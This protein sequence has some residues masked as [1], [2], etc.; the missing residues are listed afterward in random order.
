[1]HGAADRSRERFGVVRRHEERGLSPHLPETRNVAEHEGAA[2]LCCLERREAERL[3]ARRR[4]EDARA[5]HTRP[6]LTTREAAEKSK[7]RRGS[8]AVACDLDRPGETRG[9]T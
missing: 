2:G 9:D 1:M 4:A 6:Q 5:G 7:L 8:G 3:V